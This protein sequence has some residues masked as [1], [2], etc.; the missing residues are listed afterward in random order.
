MWLQYNLKASLIP[1]TLSLHLAG[2]LLRRSTISSSE[3]LRGLAGE[4]IR[5]FH[6]P[7]QLQHPNLG[8][9]RQLLHILAPPQRAAALDFAGG[10]VVCDGVPERRANLRTCLVSLHQH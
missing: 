8:P 10:P 6:P 2:L 9:Q 5:S 1:D 4:P 3:L 7:A